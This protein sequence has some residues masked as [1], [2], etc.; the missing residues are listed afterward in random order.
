MVLQPG[1]REKSPNFPG[2]ISRPGDDNVIMRQSAGPQAV[3][4]PAV[5]P[6]AVEFSRVFMPS[7]RPQ[8]QAL[9]GRLLFAATS[10]LLT[11][12]RVG[13]SVHGITSVT[14]GFDESL[15]P[16]TAN[17]ANSY[18]FGKI[19]PQDTSS[20]ITLGDILGGGFP[21]LARPSAVRSRDG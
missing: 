18:I 20:G 12:I 6:L 9:E 7:I 19:P 15:D 14:L 3:R 10:P 17:N 1:I 8:V 21:F 5:R 2:T 11:S 4:T 16:A 13:G